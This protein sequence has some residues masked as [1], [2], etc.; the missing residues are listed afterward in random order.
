MTNKKT[1]VSDTDPQLPVVGGF[2]AETPPEIIAQS[3]ADKLEELMNEAYQQSQVE[4]EL[5]SKFADWCN[6]L[7]DLW[8]EVKSHV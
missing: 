7:G 1:E 4:G 2:K 8:R 6:H 3:F 5:Q